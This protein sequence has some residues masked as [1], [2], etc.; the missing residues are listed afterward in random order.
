VDRPEIDRP[1]MSAALLHRLMEGDGSLLEGRER[2]IDALM[3]E[4]LYHLSGPFRYVPFP[5][6]FGAF[7]MFHEYATWWSIVG[8]TVLYAFG[9]WYLDRMRER[10]AVYGEGSGDAAYWGRHFAVGSAVTG[11]TWG[12]LGW[13]YFPPGN[14]ELQAVLAIVWA[15]LSFSNANTRTTHLPSYYA[16]MAAMTIPLYARTFISGERSALYMAFFGL[17]MA[18]AM[19]IWV[20][21]NYRRERLGIALR[22]R[23]AELIAELDRARAAAEASRREIEQAHRAVLADF[24]GAQALACQGSWSW[25]ADDEQMTW[26][27]EYYRLIGLAP[28]SCPASLAGL[29]EQV[30]PDDRDLVRLHY[31]RL[32]NGAAKDRVVFRLADA[33]APGE[34]REALGAAERDAQGQVRRVQGVLRIYPP[35]WDRP[36]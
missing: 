11:A 6:L 5:M 9:T 12:L 27:D 34:R 26:S 1:A 14:V 36:I 31:R 18:A 4:R 3:I 21:L 32:R 13:L 30:H 10:Y 33:V 28:Q 25:D 2:Q 7:L 16:F 20:H 23:N 35:D 17:V 15:G 29:L 19:A 22:L 24:A 8:L